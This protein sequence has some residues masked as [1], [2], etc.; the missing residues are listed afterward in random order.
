MK[1][2]LQ[3]VKRVII[4]LENLL[5]AEFEYKKPHRG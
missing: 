3:I 2:L 4:I 5:F 1:R